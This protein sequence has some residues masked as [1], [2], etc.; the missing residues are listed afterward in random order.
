MA[1]RAEGERCEVL[2]HTQVL[3][4]GAANSSGIVSWHFQPSESLLLALLEL[5]GTSY[6]KVTL[7]VLLY[8]F[9]YY[10]RV[11]GV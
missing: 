5:S 6:G 1:I 4:Y 8:G 7:R 10:I 11:R 2:P 9:T 3:P